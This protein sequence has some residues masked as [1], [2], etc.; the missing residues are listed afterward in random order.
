MEEKKVR[1][2][3][4]SEKEVTDFHIICFKETPS[5]RVERN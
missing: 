1:N 2:I 5:F 3:Y 4:F